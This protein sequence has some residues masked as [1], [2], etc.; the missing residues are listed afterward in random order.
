VVAAAVLAV[1]LSVGTGASV[2][3]GPVDSVADGVT[4]DPAAGANGDYAHLGEGGLVVDLGAAN[5]NLTG[6]GVPDDSVTYIDDVVVVRN[7]GEGRARV[8]LTHGSPSVTFRADDRSIESAR[9]AA[10]LDANEATAVGLTVDTTGKA[11]ET[12]TLLEDVTVHARVGEPGEHEPVPRTTERM[13]ETPTDEGQASIR[14][15]APS[16]TSRSFTVTNAQ[17]GDTVPLDTDR[18]VVDRVD[19]RTLTLDRLTVTSADSSVTVDVD[20]VE[21]VEGMDPG[22]TVRPLGAVDVEDSGSVTGAT[23][24]FSAAP[25]YLDAKRTTVD[26]LVDRR[27]DGDGWQSLDAKYVGTRNG[28]VVFEAA[29]PGF[30]TFA[31]GVRTS[32]LRV[33]EV[34]LQRSRMAVGE[35]TSVTARVTNTGRAS[36]ERAVG[37]TM[38]GTRIQTQSV[39]L[40]P[41]E[42]TVVRFDVAT[43]SPGRYRLD[44]GGVD[45]GTLV[46]TRPTASTE[47][48]GSKAESTTSDGATDRETANGSTGRPKSVATS[49]P[50]TAPPVAEPAGLRLPALLG[51]LGT[52]LVVLLG[53]LIARRRTDDDG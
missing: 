49:T 52:L 11:T 48:V 18:L 6:Q 12:D 39:D 10:V 5:T 44:V 4:L 2:L 32:A 22:N 15:F 3:S 41:G 45:A 1:T 36:G 17:P 53:L 40:A 50:G 47:T 7:S 27:N 14:S 13:G 43:A 16:T 37:L 9:T 51:L 26:R 19:R 23:F 33:G 38:D 34:G 25:T 35:T 20:V 28:R 42:S 8:W 24:R 31:V 30:S 21:D 46:V 29:R